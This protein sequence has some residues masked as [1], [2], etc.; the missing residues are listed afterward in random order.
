[1][2]RHSGRGRWFCAAFATAALLGFAA[3]LAP[4]VVSA[5]PIAASPSDNFVDSIGVN[6]HSTHYLGFPSTSYDDWNS[7]I[8]AVGN[9]GVRHVRDH[10]F[11][12]T[13]LNQLTAATGAKVTGI[14]EQHTFSNGVLVLDQS[15]VPT[16]LSQAKQVTGLDALEGPSEYDQYPDPNW[17]ANLRSY[18]I[19]LYNTAKADP[20]LA[21]LPVLAP[22]IAN[23]NEYANFPDLAAYADSGNVHS[24]PGTGAPTN[25]LANWLNASSQMVGAKPTWSTETG[26]HEHPTLNTNPF[27][28]SP[29]A[30]GKYLPRLL[31]DYYRAGVPRTFLYELVDDNADPTNS[32]AE[33]NLGVYKSDFTP[34]PAAIAIKN[35]ITL[36]SDPG[37]SFTPSSLD[38]TLTLTGGNANLHQV[39][40]QK[41]NGTFWLALWQDVSVFD[42]STNTDLTNPDL[43][44]TLNFASPINGAT[45]YLP[46]GSASPVGTFGPGSQL[47]L[48]VP[49]QVLLVQISIPEPTGAMLLVLGLAW[50]VNRRRR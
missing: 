43:P 37:S 47:N 21:A 16:V 29:T 40:L 35:L 20:A 13:R 39:L 46:D 17:R 26:Y 2:G 49:D 10:V 8:A 44:V 38:F 9:L 25:G 12:P 5:A 30:A 11:D 19:N 33:N 45:T 6:V 48:N 34:K 42:K 41:R 50:S 18:Q 7:V 3:A 14:I 4:L 36:L 28:I 23:P 1:M 22:S 31:M 27:D 15:S 24:Y 32:N